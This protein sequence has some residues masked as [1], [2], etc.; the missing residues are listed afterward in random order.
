LLHFEFAS[1]QVLRNAIELQSSAPFLKIERAVIVT[2]RKMK[3]SVASFLSDNE[4][5][6]KARHTEALIMTLM[7]RDMWKNWKRGGELEAKREPISALG[8]ELSVVAN[9][10]IAIYISKKHDYRHD[11]ATTSLHEDICAM[12]RRNGAALPGYHSAHTDKSCHDVSLGFTPKARMILLNSSSFAF[13]MT[14][15]NPVG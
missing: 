2:G 10:L 1:E 13:S 5:S 8:S 15:P 7:L 6:N 14:R 9:E 11:T 3:Y 12:K 4:I